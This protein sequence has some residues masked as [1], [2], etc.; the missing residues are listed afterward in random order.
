M[1]RR[2]RESAWNCRLPETFPFL[3]SY[4]DTLESITARATNSLR[5]PL[6]LRLTFWRTQM[7]GWKQLHISKLVA[8][9][10]ILGMSV[11]GQESRWKHIRHYPLPIWSKENWEASRTWDN[12]LNITGEQISLHK[13]DGTTLNISTRSVSKL[14]Y[15][16]E[17]LLLTNSGDN[18]FMFYPIAGPILLIGALKQKIHPSNH[19]FIAIEQQSLQGRRFDILLEADAD[20]YKEIISKLTGTTGLALDIGIKEKRWI[21]KGISIRIVNKSNRLSPPPPSHS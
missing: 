7:L 16:R 19:H 15:G 5:P 17:A 12:E 20:N 1:L 21:P 3:L 4:Y 6:D 11:Y 2:L 13:A 8:I 14:A 10:L 9:S 18:G